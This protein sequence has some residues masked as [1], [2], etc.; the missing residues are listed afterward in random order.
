MAD[1]TTINPGTNGDTVRDL[2]RT[3]GG[4]KTQVFALD[5]GGETTSG[6]T[7]S[8]ISNPNPLPVRPA[9]DALNTFLLAQTLAQSVAAAAASGGGFVPVETPDFLLGG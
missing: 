4:P 5:V 1:N 7:E 2:Q 9:S 3:T 6:S 8:I